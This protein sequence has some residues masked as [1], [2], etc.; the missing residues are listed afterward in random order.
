MDVTYFKSKE[1]KDN[2]MRFFYE[3]L[4]GTYHFQF[5]KNGVVMGNVELIK[6]DFVV[7]KKVLDFCDYSFDNA[8]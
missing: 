4:P 2:V 6:H 3:E 7:L 5:I 1:D 8:G